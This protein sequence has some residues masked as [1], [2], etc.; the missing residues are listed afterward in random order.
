[1]KLL[2]LV[3]P[4]ALGLLTACTAVVV[5]EPGPRPGPGPRPDRDRVCTR[6]YEPV[7][8]RR[9]QSTRT[10]PNAC[11]ARSDG[12]RPVYEGQCRRDGDRDGRRDRDD[13][14]DGRDRDDRRDRDGRRDRDRDR[15]GDRPQVCTQQYDP[16]CARRGQS[17]RTFPNSCE[18]QS[19]GYRPIYGGQCR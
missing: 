13:R 5:D 9:G 19:D 14:R 7:C 4:A 1:M 15:R 8:A 16:V 17:T 11:E 3:V 2:R 12:Y 18:A 10:F 6:Q